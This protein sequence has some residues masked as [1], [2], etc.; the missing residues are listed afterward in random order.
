[1]QRLNDFYYAWGADVA[2]IN[3]DGVND[4]IS[5]GFYYLGPAYTSKREFYTTQTWS[6]GEEYVLDMMTYAHDFTGDGWPDVVLPER[7]PLVM[8][9]NPQGQN[10]RWQRVEALPMVSGETAIKG[11]LDRDGIP[12][13]VFVANDGTVAYGKPNRANPT[14][15][16]DRPEDLRGRRRQPWPGHR[17][18]ERRRTGR[19]P[20]RERLVGAAGST[21]SGR[22][23][24]LPRRA[25]RPVYTPGPASW[26]RR[27]RGVRLQRRQA[28]RRRVEPQR[29][30]VGSR[31][32][33]QK[34]GADGAISFTEH[35]IMD[36]YSTKNAGNVTFSQL[37]SG[38]TLIDVDRDGVMDFV[39]GKR[40]WSH[41][42]SYTDPDPYG[43][44]VVYWYRTVRNPKAPGGVEFVPELI[45]NRSG[46]GS[47]VKAVDINKDGA[48]DLVTSGTKGT[49]VFWGVPA[50]RN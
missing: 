5:G 10:R 35:V 16:W 30:R 26:R 48:T 8:Y 2:D 4:I 34:R 3:R 31:V 25:L 46:V 37:H 14:G 24:D 21:D 1:M 38:A 32:D 49:F 45:H 40:H 11:D 33:E 12:E 28:R 20:S 43:P 23:V 36:N 50:K 29:A 15:P 44:A 9:V 22:T 41:L 18:R 27:N 17:R 19:H 6:P 47:E 13:I 7:R 39:T 42:D